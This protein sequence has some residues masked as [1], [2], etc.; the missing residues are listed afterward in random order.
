MFKNR[1]ITFILLT[2][3][4]VSGKAYCQE[5]IK[6]QQI[7]TIVGKVSKIDLESSV[8][9]IETGSVAKQAFSDAHVD[10]CLIWGELIKN[11][12]IDPN[13]TIQPRFYALNKFSDILLPKKFNAKKKLIYS[14]FQKALAD[15]GIMVFYTSFD[16]ELLRGTHRI[17]SVEI[18]KGDPVTIQYNSSSPDKNNIIRLVDNK[19]DDD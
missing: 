9:N 3:V 5:Q 19:P 10:S 1:V 13:G 8:I 2:A 12:Y 18:E 7:R 16:S 6:D 15:N 11:G 14:I 4:L 17:V